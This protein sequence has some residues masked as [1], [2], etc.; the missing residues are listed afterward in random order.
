MRAL[1]VPLI[2]ILFLNYP[3]SECLLRL[4]DR[5]IV[6]QVSV[7]LYVKIL[8][9]TVTCWAFEKGSF[10]YHEKERLFEIPFSS[11]WER[12]KGATRN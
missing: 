12:W 7:S 3:A 8:L 1:P 11:I 4:L 2:P 6:T 10:I 9:S 5:A